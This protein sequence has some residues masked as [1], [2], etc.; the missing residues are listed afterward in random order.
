MNFSCPYCAG[1]SFRLVSDLAGSQ[2]ATCNKCGKTTPFEHRAMTRSEQKLLKDDDLDAMVRADQKERW[3]AETA[4]I[5]RLKASRL[6]R[7][8][9]AMPKEVSEPTVKEKNKL[10]KR[11]PQ[12]GKYL[13]GYE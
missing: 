10:I 4:K 3:D 11:K 12:P 9:Q 1:D 7:D 6:A 13:G 2:F 5:A 8:A